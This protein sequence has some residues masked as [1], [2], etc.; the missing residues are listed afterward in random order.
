[1]VRFHT[2]YAQLDDL[3]VSVD[4]MV[5]RDEIIGKAKGGGRQV[6]FEIRKDKVPVNPA[7]FVTNLRRPK[8]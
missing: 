4:A 1:S 3:Y 7:L 6:Y 8:R 5:E 2:I